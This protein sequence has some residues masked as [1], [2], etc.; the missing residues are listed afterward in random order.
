MINIQNN[1]CQSKKIIFFPDKIYGEESGARSARAT[2][3]S[4]IELGYKVAVF[5]SDADKMK[6]NEIEGSLYF[7]KVNS[8]MRANAH[9]HEPKLMKQFR[10]IV[11]EFNP[12]FF[13]TAGSIQKPAILAKESR[14]LGIKTI[15][16]FYITDYYCLKTYAGLETG[17]CFQ[18]IE[19]GALASLKNNCLKDKHKLINLIK[20][21]AVR[22]SIQSE[23]RNSFKVAGYSE[24]QLNIYKMLGV[25]PERCIKINFQFDPTELDNIPSAEG[26]YF[27]LYGQPSVEKGWHTLSQIISLLK[28]RIKI[29]IVFQNKEIEKNMLAKF[30]LEKFLLDGTIETEL[31]VNNREDILKRVAN[32]KAVLIP[33]YYPTTGEFVLLESLIFG[34]PVL[35]F[36]SGAHNE[37]IKQEQ[38][39]MIANIGDLETFACNID[40]ININKGL[41]DSISINAKKTALEM[42]ENSNTLFSISRLFN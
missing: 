10:N 7:F 3:K 19:K 37:I 28:T 22:K 35:V 31:H 40:K 33:S 32:S 23:M 6:H 42:F 36:K 24:S 41:R 18:C 20:S 30:G 17:P 14:R 21:T 8:L 5:S 26:E 27:L 1:N 4:M 9:F 38:N 15:F 16:L 25:S 12:D 11:K 29:K 13:F 2:L 39:G 34:K